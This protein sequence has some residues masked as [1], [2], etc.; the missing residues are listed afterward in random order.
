VRMPAT[1]AARPA[2]SSSES[3]RPIRSPTRTRMA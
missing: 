1:S 3:R 2:S